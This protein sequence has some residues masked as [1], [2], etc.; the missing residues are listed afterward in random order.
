MA[1]SRPATITADAGRSPS[2]RAVIQWSGLLPETGPRR[3]AYF[4]DTQYN[5]VCPHTE[6]LMTNLCS[7][8]R[9]YMPLRYEEERSE[10]AGHEQ[11]RK[12]AMS[13]NDTRPVPYLPG[14]LEGKQDA[15][16]AP[17]QPQP[18]IREG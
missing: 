5:D 12:G 11:T 10:E 13:G 6:W 17:Q 9:I 15:A 4:K 3:L 16:M 14:T 7:H 18:R 1:V 2:V 8:R